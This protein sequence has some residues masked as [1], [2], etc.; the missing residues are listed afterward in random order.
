M[1]TTPTLYCLP[2]S[3]GSSYSY[4]DLETAADGRFRVEAIE[5]AGHGRRMAEPLATSVAALVDD[6]AIQIAPI[7]G[8]PY[9]FYGHSLGALLAYHLAMRFLGG[10]GPKPVHL[11]VSGKQGPSV[12][13][14]EPSRHLL[15]EAPFLDELRRLGGAPEEVLMDRELMELF[16]PILRADFEAVDTYMHA[17]APPLSIPITAFLGDCDEATVEEAQAWERETTAQFRLH[18][19]PGDHFFVHDHW[20]AICDTMAGILAGDPTGPGG[21]ARR[22]AGIR[23]TVCEGELS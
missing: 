18:V 19:L 21:D 22:D 3:G 5:L 15:A 7:H 2:F 17:S 13:R 11:F 12:S 16:L 8:V 23:G 6:A 10:G 4:R 20:P 14:T 1:K 9:A